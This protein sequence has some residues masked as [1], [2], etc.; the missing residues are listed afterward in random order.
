V[1]RILQHYTPNFKP[2]IDLTKPIHKEY[3]KRHGYSFNLKEVPEYPVYNG[4]EKL[5]QILEVCKEN[6]AALVMDADVLITNH[7]I[8]IENQFSYGKT[9][10]FSKGLNMGVFVIKNCWFSISIIKLMI[11]LIEKGV[12][13]CEQDAIEL[14]YSKKLVYESTTETR[15]HPCFNSYL[16][17]LYPEIPQPVTKEQ[18]QWEKGCFILHVPALSIEKRIEV[19]NNIKQHIVYE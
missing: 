17:E 6:D 1:I 10:S 8:K 12:C 18:G 9:L 16:S 4:L 7:T 13:N 14:I 11:L 15:K 3:C 2:L 19:L 5:N